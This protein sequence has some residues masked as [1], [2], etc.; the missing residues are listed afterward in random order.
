MFVASALRV[1]RRTGT[2]LGASTD[3]WKLSPLLY[4]TS[5]RSRSPWVRFNFP[6]QN[7][8]RTQP[9]CPLVRIP[10]RA[11]GALAP[12]DQPLPNNT[13]KSPPSQKSFDP[14]GHT[15]PVT[16][17][18]QRKADWFVI[19]KLMQ[20]VWPRQDWNTRGRVILGFTLLVSG[21]VRCEWDR[22]LWLQSPKFA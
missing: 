1:T 4:H 5:A 18:E 2:R 16:N 7:W 3:S 8:L 12:K 9:R 15:G 14:I 22:F 10:S 11:H 20:H 17:A 21:K 19:R 13:V 6:S